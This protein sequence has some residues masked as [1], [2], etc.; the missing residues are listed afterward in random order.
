MFYFYYYYYCCPRRE[1]LL[2]FEY[3]ICERQQVAARARAVQLTTKI[4]STTRRIW[5]ACFVKQRAD[6]RPEEG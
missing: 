4:D 2:L 6:L 5:L 1:G 3:L